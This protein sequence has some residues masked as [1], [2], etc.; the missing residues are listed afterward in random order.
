M[1]LTLPRLLASS[2]IFLH[3][4]GEGKRQVMVEALAGNDVL[5]L[6]VRAMLMQQ[7]TPVTVYISS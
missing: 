4:C 2:K 7:Q 3:L 6:P 5:A 1:S